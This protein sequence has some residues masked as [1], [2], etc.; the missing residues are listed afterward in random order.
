[1]E[2]VSDINLHIFIQ[3]SDVSSPKALSCPSALLRIQTAGDNHIISKGN[4]SVEGRQRGELRFST[5]S[6]CNMHL[7]Y[8]FYSA[9][10]FKMAALAKTRV[11]AILPHLKHLAG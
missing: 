5:R 3:A 9:C 11:A 2:G 1:M 4:P 8:L 10:V 7:F 6:S